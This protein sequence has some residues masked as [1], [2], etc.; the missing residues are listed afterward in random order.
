M[1]NAWPRRCRRIHL[2]AST[3]SSG[4]SRVDLLE[5]ILNAGARPDKSLSPR[6][7]GRWRRAQEPTR[8]GKGFIIQWLKDMGIVDSQSVHID[9]DKNGSP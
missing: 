6:S 1:C 7:I 8:S 9:V 5:A 2:A 3:S 4:G